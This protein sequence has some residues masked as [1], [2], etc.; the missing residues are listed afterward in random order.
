VVYPDS[1][2]PLNKNDVIAEKKFIDSLF[3][4][5]ALQNQI[6]TGLFCLLK[7]FATQPSLQFSNA[8]YIYLTQTQQVN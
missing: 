6:N 4:V 7:L 2:T 5:A 8:F 3:G 1:A